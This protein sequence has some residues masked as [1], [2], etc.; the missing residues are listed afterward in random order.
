[1]V[2]PLL[3]TGCFDA[4]SYHLDLGSFIIKTFKVDKIKKLLTLYKFIFK[5]NL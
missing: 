1:M 4:S 3:P 2:L 5:Y